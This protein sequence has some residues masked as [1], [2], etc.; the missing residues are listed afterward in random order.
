[1]QGRA[2]HKTT[3]LHIGPSIS[4]HVNLGEGYISKKGYQRFVGLP[5]LL[6]GPDLAPN[7]HGFI[8]ASRASG[9]GTQ[10]TQ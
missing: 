9:R 10:A 2:P 8:E 7:V 5:A 1:M 6:E 3:A 4:F